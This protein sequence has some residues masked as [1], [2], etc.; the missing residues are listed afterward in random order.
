MQCV[1]V[2]DFAELNDVTRG[3]ILTISVKRGTMILRFKGICAC[4][5]T[6]SPS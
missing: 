3:F 6:T 5:S 2:V 1:I 4:F